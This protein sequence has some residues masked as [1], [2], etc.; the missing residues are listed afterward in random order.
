MSTENMEFC[1]K[2]SPCKCGTGGGGAKLPDL[3]YEE[4]E[5]G[6]NNVDG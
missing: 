3:S 6:F 4:Q 2:M 5:A 1:L